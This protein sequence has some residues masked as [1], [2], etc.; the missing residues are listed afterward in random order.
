MS[1]GGLERQCPRPPDVKYYPWLIFL[2]TFKW[3]KVG[4]A[5][6]ETSSGVHIVGRHFWNN[7][8]IVYRSPL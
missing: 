4:V 2:S 3:P 6:R 1:P 5:I 7:K 8:F